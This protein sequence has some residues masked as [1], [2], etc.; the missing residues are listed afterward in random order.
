MKMWNNKTF[1][2]AEYLVENL[3]PFALTSPKLVEAT[4]VAIDRPEVA[5]IPALQRK[6][7]EHLAPMQRALKV[8]AQDH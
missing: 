7:V 8:Q 2:M 4:K 3:F 1:K 5:A 6:L